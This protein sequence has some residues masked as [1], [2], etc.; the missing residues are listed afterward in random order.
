MSPGQP[1]LFSG[2][3][4]QH[5]SARQMH[6]IVRL[7]AGRAGISKRFGVHT[8]RHRGRSP[9][10]PIRNKAVVY[11]LLLKVAAESLITIAPTGQARGL[12]AHD[13][14]HLGGAHRAHRRAPH[15]G[16]RAH[17][18]SARPY[19]RP[20]RRRLTQAFPAEGRGRAL[21]RLPARLLPLRAGPTSCPTGSIASVIT[22]S[23]P[24]PTGPAI[25]NWPAGSSAC[26]QRRRAVTAM[27]PKRVTQ[28]Q[29]GRLVLAAVAEWSSSRPSNP[30][31]SP[32]YGPSRQS[33][34]IPRDQH[35]RVD[36]LRRCACPTPTSRRLRPRSS[37][38]NRRLPPSS[39][40][41]QIPRHDITLRFPPAA[42][43]SR[44]QSSLG[45]RPNP[46]SKNQIKPRR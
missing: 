27:A 22:A 25:S 36:T 32:G 9:T 40:K 3:C 21:D 34:S 16:I 30:A 43:T 31:A 2:Y 10:S 11:D 23:S 8:L 17:P 44:S 5:T 7:E 28:T 45:G 4:G 29:S 39:A 42:P 19:H 37:D 14:K 33:G 46:R 35:A 15:L 41:T 6:R 18:P 20:R 13:P 26:P 12:K 1:W 24:M 38:G